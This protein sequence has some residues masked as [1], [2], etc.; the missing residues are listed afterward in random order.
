ML[1]SVFPLYLRQLTTNKLSPATDGIFGMTMHAAAADVFVLPLFCLLYLFFFFLTN[2][3][4]Q[5]ENSEIGV[6][7]SRG[8]RHLVSL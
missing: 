2:T 3:V 5:K 1:L 4:P 6:S 8:L 7:C